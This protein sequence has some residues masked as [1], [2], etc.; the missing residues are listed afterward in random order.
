MA[1]VSTLSST[2]GDVILACTHLKSKAGYQK[3][4]WKSIQQLLAM[5]S[6]MRNNNE[7]VF[8]L[9][10]FNAEPTEVPSTYEEVINNSLSF[11][12]AYS[13]A[14]SE[15]EYTTRYDSI[16]DDEKCHN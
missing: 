16:F 11:K 1:L 9:G 6:A 2:S 10:D 8:I 4:R 13:I 3:R 12:S 7:H 15:P 5:L 14:G